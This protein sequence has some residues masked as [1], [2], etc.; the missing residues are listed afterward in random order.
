MT[1]T[2]GKTA[3]PRRFSVSISRFQ[4]YVGLFV[5][6]AGAFF[7]PLQ[8]P[9]LGWWLRGESA[10]HPWRRA[11]VSTG[12]RKV[13]R[14]TPVRAPPACEQ[15]DLTRFVGGSTCSG[16]YEQRR[17]PWRKLRPALQQSVVGMR[18]RL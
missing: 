17:A 8:R 1:E 11:D 18:C 12:W 13:C 3:H 4:C 15:Q 16:Q 5:Y 2:S 9:H 10:L 14:Y 7:S 6:E